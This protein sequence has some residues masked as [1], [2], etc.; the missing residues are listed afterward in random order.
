MVPQADLP[1]CEQ[2]NKTSFA[3]PL[4]YQ[5]APELMNQYVKAFEKVWAGKAELAAL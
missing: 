2:L 5:D 1:G 4:F 3:L